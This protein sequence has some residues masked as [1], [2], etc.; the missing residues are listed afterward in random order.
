MNDKTTFLLFYIGFMVCV[1]PLYCHRGLYLEV[2]PAQGCKNDDRS[3]N[4]SCILEASLTSIAKVTSLTILASRLYGDEGEFDPIA[5]IDLWSKE[6]QVMNGIVTQEMNLAGKIGTAGEIKSQLSFSWKTPSNREVGRYKCVA[7]GL[8]ASRRLVSISVTSAVDTGDS[9]SDSSLSLT[10]IE[11]LANNT[12]NLDDKID[13]V[14]I[15][16]DTLQQNVENLQE[17]VTAQDRTVAEIYRFVFVMSNFDASNHF[18]GKR[19]YIS[20]VLL[21]SFDFQTADAECAIIG[22]HLVEIDTRDEFSFVFAFASHVGGSEHFFTSANDKDNEGT[23][24]FYHSQQ[25]VSFFSWASRQPDNG[26]NTYDFED[27]MEIN[28]KLQGFNDLPCN[29]AGKFI[30]ETKI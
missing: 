6:P 26:G 9:N 8:D 28:I 7:N 30:C 4:I 2:K 3:Q 27:C 25:P 5:T 16:V 1:R 13:Q 14:D 10:L 15:K 24:M 22:G 19:Y 11:G 18:R 29:H 20:K 17:M 21:E 23:W 12:M